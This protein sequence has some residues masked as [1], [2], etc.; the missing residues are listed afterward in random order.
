MTYPFK[1]NDKILCVNTDGSQ[2]RLKLNRI[3]HVTAARIGHVMVGG[4]NVTWSNTRFIS[5]GPNPTKLQLLLW[6]AE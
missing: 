4:Y 3:Y 6:G 1:I 2:G 5:L